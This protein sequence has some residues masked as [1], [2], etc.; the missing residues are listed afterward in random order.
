MTRL[1]CRHCGGIV[2]EQPH[3][4]ARSDLAETLREGP[5]R[6]GRRRKAGA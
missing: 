6:P 5:S 1:R 2:V 4:A 3:P